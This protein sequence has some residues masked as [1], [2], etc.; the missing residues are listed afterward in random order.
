M[1]VRDPK[2]EVLDNGVVLLS[3]E[4]RETRTVALRG[5]MPAGSFREAPEQAGLASFA[6][7]LLRRGT[8]RHTAQQISA[9]VEDLGASFAVWAGS[10]ETGFSAKCLDRDLAA[11][12]DVLR[13][14]LEDPEFAEDE[15]TKVRGEIHTELEEI[16]DSPRALADRAISA[17]LYPPGHPYSRAPIGTRET[18]DGLRRADFQ[19]FHQAHYGPR[20]LVLSVAGALD[21]E[22]LRRSLSG[23][24]PARADI[25]T[26]VDPRPF[27][28][29]PSAA[30]GLERI[31]LPHKS[32]VAVILAG[33][34]IPRDH[35]DYLP[36][37]M[38]NMILGSLGL[39]GRL[40]ERVRDQHGMAYSV[41]CR[42]NSR[43]WSG[44]WVAGAG[45]SPGNED[46]AVELILDEVRRIREEL[47]TEEEHADVQANLIGSLPLRMETSDG[48]AG[49]LLSTE[50]Y[51]LGLDYIERYPDLVRG[52]TREAMRE[53][54]RLHMDPA[55]FSRVVAGPV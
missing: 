54:A 41:S 46:R 36:L 33:P 26:P 53:A 13:E 50:Y 55:G 44:E 30:A 51:D 39:M 28:V 40:G 1:S 43:L 25:P 15:I 48:V 7:R 18:V 42:A 35:P 52:V 16:E 2:R 24:F 32:Q 38:V 49:Y 22:T 4:S 34:G 31:S 23:W 20:S 27:R 29:T 37:A 21:L 8:R 6:A 12:L 10:E 3:S 9:R 11:V 19:A 5:S 45:V 14:V 17:M 47:V